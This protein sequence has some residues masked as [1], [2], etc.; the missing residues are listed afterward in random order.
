MTEFVILGRGE[1]KSSY[2]HDWLR[3]SEHNYAIVPSGREKRDMCAR[4]RQI[5]PAE[6]AW[7]RRIHGF[8]SMMSM[9]RFMADTERTDAQARFAIDDLDRFLEAFLGLPIALATATSVEV[10]L[11]AS[12]PPEDGEVE[13]LDEVFAPPRSGRRIRRDGTVMPEH[14]RRIVRSPRPR[15]VFLD[16]DDD[17]F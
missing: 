1:G 3:A 10:E 14:S 15:P 6:R 11:G 2:I 4:M 9:V 8:T 17:E 5:H 7:Q 13:G 12:E 16:E